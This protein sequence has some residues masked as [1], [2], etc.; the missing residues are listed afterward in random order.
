ML[1][2]VIATITILL[3]CLSAL[4]LA[5]HVRGT[6][7]MPPPP[8]F[9]QLILLALISHSAFLN[10]SLFK[11]Q[12]LHLNFFTVP[13]L[14][15][16]I[17]VAILWA[18]LHKRQPIEN[19]LLVF[20]PLTAISIATAAWAPSANTKTLTEPGLITHIVLSIIAYSLITIAAL[21]AAML[22]AQEHALK[23]HRSHQMIKFFPPL[24]T[25]EKL[26]F[27]ILFIGFALLSIA[28]ASGFVFLDDMFAQHLA[29]KTLLSILAWLIFAI[30]LYG[31]LA[32]G[33]RGNTAARLT[34]GGFIVLM[35]AY[36]GS[37]F[38]LEVVLHRI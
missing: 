5:M 12:L 1:H 28:I 20:L 35:L 34:I 9:R 24:Q 18:A 7:T 25:M 11:D 14:I 19:L 32:K 27:Q 6:L 23:N 2:S 17:I 3:Y 15:F 21:Q 8:I 26:L 29:H 30:L 33:W 22:T 37:K 31:R 13:P 38:V 16:F 36:F 4:L 10:V